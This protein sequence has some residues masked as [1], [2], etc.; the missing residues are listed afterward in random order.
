MSTDTSGDGQ[1]A[2]RVEGL[3]K[4]FGDGDDAVM[5]IDGISFAI[6]TGNV[7]GMLGP[8]GARKTTTIKSMLGLVLPDACHG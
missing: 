5:A 1:P 4:S 6:E 2:I 7:V 3:R 8:N